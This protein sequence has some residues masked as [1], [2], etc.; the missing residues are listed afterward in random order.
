ME[1]NYLSPLKDLIDRQWRAHARETQVDGLLLTS[2][3]AP[4]GPIHAV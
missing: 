2:V 3:A 1:T 4:T